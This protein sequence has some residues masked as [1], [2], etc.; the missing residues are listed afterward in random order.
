[1]EF[2]CGSWKLN[3]EIGIFKKMFKDENLKINK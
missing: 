1:M 3:L 2:Y